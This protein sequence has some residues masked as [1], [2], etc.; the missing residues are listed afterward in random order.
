MPKVNPEITAHFSLFL[1]GRTL[2]G[3]MLGGWKPKSDLPSLVEMYL[4]KVR[5]T[6]VTVPGFLPFFTC[7]QETD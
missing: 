1:A 5:V 4:R 7:A 6:T 2:R 3:S